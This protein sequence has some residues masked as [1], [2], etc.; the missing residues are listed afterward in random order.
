MKNI[1]FS[2]MALVGAGLIACGT[3]SNDDIK[4]A[5]RD[6]DAQQSSLNLKVGETITR[7]RV[8][9]SRGDVGVGLGGTS[10]IQYKYE[11]GTATVCQ[12]TAAAGSTTNC[13]AFQ[14]V[15]LTETTESTAVVK[16]KAD[17]AFS[18]LPGFVVEETRKETTDEQF[19]YPVAGTNSSG[20]VPSTTTGNML[21]TVAEWNNFVVQVGE[22]GEGDV[23]NSTTL[24]P[25][26]P[27]AGRTYTDDNGASWTVTGTELVTAGPTSVRAAAITVATDK[28][29]VDLA[30]L[31]QKCF[32]RV[33][34]GGTSTTNYDVDMAAECGGTLQLVYDHT[35]QVGLDLVLRETK[36]TVEIQIVQWGVRDAAGVLDRTNV[37]NTV[38]SDY[39]FFYTARE[40]EVTDEVTSITF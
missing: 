22:G 20:N 1:R 37:P 35:M 11:K 18:E 16:E 28:N 30:E 27:A 31:Q 36:K 8:V 40:V 26:S 19:L 5:L 2:M 6:A 39:V 15:I 3:P 25:V 13:G 33:P 34:S 14:S 10:D 38:I 4:D 23:G 7:K 9:V 32:T 21:Y 29:I 12:H 24:F 17:V